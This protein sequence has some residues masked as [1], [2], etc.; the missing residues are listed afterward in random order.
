[1]AVDIGSRPAGSEAEEAAAD[2]ITSQLESWGY[3]VEQQPFVFEAFADLGTTLEIVSPQ[4][5]MLE[6]LPM[7]STIAGLVEAE[8]VGAGLGRPGDFPTDATAR[9]A[10]IERGE[11]EF[12]D[13]VANATAAGAAAAIIYN[14]DP[15]AFSGLL[16]RESA[17]PAV[18]ISREEGQL[19]IDLL[20]AGPVTIRLDVR[21]MMGPN[22]SQNVIGRPPQEACQVF[23]GGHYDSV[24]VGPGANDNASGTA[25][26]LELARAVADDDEMDPVC[27]LAFGAEE[28]GLFGSREFVADL[29]L[30][31]RQAAI[32][33]LNLDMVGVGRRWLLVGS[34]ALTDIVVEEADRLGLTY[35]VGSLPASTSSD[36]VS[37]QQVG[38]PALILHREGDPRYHTAEDRADFIDPELL[39]EAGRLGLALV[40]VLLAGR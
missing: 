25:T 39:L 23:V 29:A 6:P 26:L 18:S 35:V 21:V 36:H 10:L 19:I 7:R 27:F 33:M 37:F 40:E 9:M 32:A 12:T 24:A 5:Q 1:L 28:V 8:I 16:R 20:A 2:Y 11:I 31:E 15:G 4:Q 14:S 3:E 34:L 38:I 17:I 13:K 22:P 30:E